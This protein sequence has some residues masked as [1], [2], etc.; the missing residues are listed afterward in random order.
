MDK[1]HEQHPFEDDPFLEGMGSPEEQRAI[2]VSRA[3]WALMDEDNVQ[4]DAR[5]RELIWPEAQRLSF[6][7]S[8]ER[9][10]QE[11]PD[12]PR[13]RITSFLTSWLEHYA[14]DD[15]SPEQLDELDQLTEQWINELERQREAQ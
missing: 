4:L 13:Q 2:E 15:Y 12:V 10:Q 11:Y 9:I 8:I 3:L 7:Q 5:R 14:P 1:R 6:D